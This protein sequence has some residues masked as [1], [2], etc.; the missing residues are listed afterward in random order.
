MM[1][2][3][4]E[5]LLHSLKSQRLHSVA[6]GYSLLQLHTVCTYSDIYTNDIKLTFTPC[7]NKT[8]SKCPS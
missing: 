7:A 2:F 3:N 5:V 1:E 8:G 4:M 6:V